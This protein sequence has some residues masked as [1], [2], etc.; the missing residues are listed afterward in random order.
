MSRCTVPAPAIL[1]ACGPLALLFALIL[2][3]CA[4][5]VS[6]N[7]SITTTSL[8]NGQVGS[9]YS[10]QLTATGGTAPYS[11]AITSGALPAGLALNA[12]TGAITGTPTAA[13]DPSLSFQVT[14]SANPARTSSAVL[15][16]TVAGVTTPLSI[17]TAS[18]PDG[19]VGV[20]Y[21]VSLAATGGTTPYMWAT[22]G[23]TLPAGLSLNTATGAISGTP[24]ASVSGASLTFQVTDSSDPAQTE[25]VVLS[26][27]IAAAAGPPALEIRTTSLPSGQLGIA[28]SATLTATG[29]TPP[30]GWT[31]TSGTLPAGLTL[32]ASTGVI[33]G[34]PTAIAS[35][36]SLTFKVMDSGNPAQTK[37][38]AL[39]LTIAP[40][41]LTI[42]T[43][44]LPNGQVGTSYSATLTATGGTPPYAWALT[45]GALPAGLTFSASG[46]LSGKPTATASGA[47]LTFKVSDSG[48]PVQTQSKTLPLTINP[49]GVI[50][51]S[52]S[53]A[54][55]GLAIGQKLVV[56]ATTNDTAGVT[57]SISPSGGSFN[58][59]SSMSGA[60]VTF[61]APS[62]AGVYTVTATSV[63]SP[64]VSGS[65]TVGVTD[66][67]G[68]YTYHDD[69][70]RTGANTHE[71]ALTPSN[72]N[73]GTFGQLFSCTVDGA[74]YAQPLWVAQLTVNGS[75]HNVVFVATAH[76]SLFA[77][78]ADTSP[79][80]QLWQVSLIDT[81]HGGTGGEVT[82]P[83][84]PTGNKVGGG[85]GDITPEVGVI[86]TP[87]VD[88]ST[89]TLYVVSKSMNSAGT[90]FYQRLHAID[91][92]TGNERTGAPVT[93]AASF[94]GTGAGGTTVPFSPQQE[95]QRAGLTFVN[96]T[97]YIAWGSHE[98]AAPWY[99]WIIGYTYNGSA[100]TQGPVLNVTPNVSEGGIWMS[101]G[102]PAADSNGH[103]YVITGNGGFDANSSTAPNNDYGD[104]FL[105]LSSS[106]G[107]LTY[108]TPS[109]EETDDTKDKDFGSG[110]SALVLNLSSGPLQ[111]LIVGGGKDG[112]LYLL[113]GDS[114]GG[115]GDANARQELMLGQGIFATGAFWNN[116]YYI[117]PASGALQAYSF[118]TT[119]DLLST[120]AASASAATFGWPGAT[121]SVSASGTSSNGIVW[122]LNTHLY[123]TKQSSGCGPAVLY[124]YDASDLATELWDSG[125]VAADAAGNAV[126][127]TVP[128]VANGKVYIGTRGTNTGATYTSGCVCGQLN[129]YGLRPN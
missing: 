117:A 64:S 125:M 73:T 55:A 22:T 34:T 23:G 108:F 48:S 75:I 38:I 77:F 13:A 52:V 59:T 128:T 37:S 40:A 53:P 76:D 95:N 91:P 44:S 12:S 92:T 45:S 20:A 17:T 94:P 104:S 93:I 106:L 36:V 6:T 5:G 60:K 110:G 26:L 81:N 74:V 109:D 30:Y 99:G 9:A 50:S 65:L 121:P 43:A 96:G 16:L 3:G 120:T 83:D 67:A 33:S 98:D 71:F 97:V 27:T 105:Q 84:G 19:Q 49:A 111:H 129:V 2:A 123:C 70:A 89:D 18:L 68:A 126:K 66:L 113:N 14:D 69:V 85:D 35:A 101:G 28:Y 21:S 57:W 4:V 11:W 124:A 122:A 127:F 56:I 88:P 54:R 112:N 62:S 119:T 31:L 29:G 80:V 25:S 103:L 42:T 63:T 51:V 115:F 10:A 87:V 15:A 72:V 100:F 79:C 78:D 114:M 118:N 46:V 58:P 39:P 107:V 90:S 24:T 116:T 32:N 61:T 86:G 7:L 47:A 82:V 102:A 8:P 1:R 41:T